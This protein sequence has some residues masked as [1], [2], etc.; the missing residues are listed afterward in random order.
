MQQM[1]RSWIYMQVV[2][3][4]LVLMSIVIAAIKL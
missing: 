2:I 3:V 1:P 4:V